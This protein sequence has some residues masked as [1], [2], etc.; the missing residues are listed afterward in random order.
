LEQT[1]SSDEW[2]IIEKK[3]EKADSADDES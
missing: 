1:N 2:A 3:E